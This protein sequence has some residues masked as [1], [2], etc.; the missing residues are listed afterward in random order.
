MFRK[1]DSEARGGLG[2][3]P[4]GSFLPPALPWEH[5]GFLSDMRCLYCGSELALLKKLAGEGQFCS[6]VH[7]QKY[8]DEFSQLALN[9]LMQAQ[10]PLPRPETKNARPVT[11][12]KDLEAVPPAVAPAPRVLQA[13]LPP[14]SGAPKPPAPPRAPQPN[15]LPTAPPIDASANREPVPPSTD[16]FRF[17]PSHGVAAEPA[18][19]TAAPPAK[20]QTGPVSNKL[21]GYRIYL[22]DSQAA[23][24]ESRPFHQ[25]AFKAVVP[26]LPAA[27]GLRTCG[28][29]DWEDLAGLALTEFA[30]TQRT[31]EAAQEVSAE[32]VVASPAASEAEAAAT[33]VA[34]EP[35]AHAGDAEEAPQAPAATGAEADAV[36]DPGLDPPEPGEPAEPADFSLAATLARLS[37][38]SEP[39]TPPAPVECEMEPPEPRPLSL[40]GRL[41]ERGLVKPKPRE[42]RAPI[43]QRCREL[44][45]APPVISPA[46]M[47]AHP[48]PASVRSRG[49]PVELEWTEST[50]ITLA[51]TGGDFFEQGA[52]LIASR[53]HLPAA[54]PSPNEA[55][56]AGETAG[57]SAL[58]PAPPAPIRC[59]RLALT[60][61]TI[62]PVPSGFEV[63]EIS[64]IPVAPASPRIHLPKAGLLPFRPR[65][66]FAPMPDSMR[67]PARDTE[68]Q[69]A[70]RRRSK[71]PSAISL[72]EPPPAPARAE[73]A[74]PA[75]PEPPVQLAANHPAPRPNTPPPAPVRPSEP[76]PKPAPPAPVKATNP[77]PESFAIPAFARKLP[78]PPAGMPGWVKIALPLVLVAAGGGW[79]AF[80]S[81]ATASEPAAAPRVN[82]SEGSQLNPA[83]WDIEPAADLTGA[84]RDRRISV[85]K[86]SLTVHDYRLS[87][88]GTITSKAVG[89]AFRVSDLKNYYAMKIE[90]GQPG[91][92]ARLVRWAVVDGQQQPSKSI[93]LPAGPA[94]SGSGLAVFRV[95][96]E[97]RGSRA[98]TYIGGAR[99]DSWTDSRLKTGGVGFLS[100]RGEKADYSDVRISF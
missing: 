88:T 99:V 91:T 47:A 33:P 51:L 48:A 80:Q 67:P 44:A 20:P 83:G 16:P 52:A 66:G 71:A 74:K 35:V 53:G 37:E 82:P 93:D 15:P 54:S 4:S 23:A 95:R 63:R 96:L 78:P 92:P 26:A 31:P 90:L 70:R 36:A 97:V 6:D 72:I 9:R 60:P 21:A 77:E 19:K 57:K 81:S 73:P 86:P 42:E 69:E 38:A 58:E 75:I 28:F 39:V 46:A 79:F 64:V 34:L 56:E 5:E 32:S 85:Y 18:P 87:F 43:P 59:G 11:K 8:Q 61:L 50:A 22:P 84:A 100:E 40:H 98:S 17:A 41:R 14:A 7:R 65:F 89:W 76:A 2:C 62:A 25:V 45:A 55:L 30:A 3:F 49:F 68:E 13:P 12:P 1:R 94:A 27:A 24:P 10:T 29:A